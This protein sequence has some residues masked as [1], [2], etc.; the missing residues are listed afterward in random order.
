MQIYPYSVTISPSVHTPLTDDH[1]RN[2]VSWFSDF[3]YVII[4]RE[5]RPGDG[6][7]HLHILFRDTPKGTHNVTRKLY[8]MFDRFN[9]PYCRGVTI[10]VVKAGSPR[11]WAG[12]CFKEVE[13]EDDL[14]LIL[15][16]GY[17]YGWAF[18]CISDWLA[19]DKIQSS[20]GKSSHRRKFRFTHATKNTIGEMIMDYLEREKIEFQDDLEWFGKI[21][22]H[23]STECWMYNV[24][25]LRVV[26]FENLCSIYGFIQTAVD[27]AYF[28]YND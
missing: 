27:H 22:A 21:W 9:I 12:Y 19:H 7:P 17:S 10:R 5:D 15:I 3:G 11:I 24:D 6:T 8:S 1:L 28:R 23:M 2:I 14:D 13:S 20:K 25:R 4:T 16:Q 18:D 26:V